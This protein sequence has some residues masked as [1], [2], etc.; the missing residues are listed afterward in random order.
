[1][2][3]IA[4]IN[5]PLNKQVWIG[6][7]YIHGVGQKRAVEI[8]K[9]AG[10]LASKDVRE[11]REDEIS[12]LREVIDSKYIVEGELRREVSLNIKNL[13]DIKCYKGIRHMR[14]LPVHGQRTHSNARTRK[15][16]AVAIANK[17]KATK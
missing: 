16:K 15:G 2:A 8:C 6:L 13:M 17:K 1:M 12:K 10:V 11:L 7:T 14:R 9:E 5:I 4:G 3:R